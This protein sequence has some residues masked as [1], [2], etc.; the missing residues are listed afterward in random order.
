MWTQQ[1]EQDRSNIK[2]VM[3]HLLNHN[4]KAVKKAGAVGI[5]A[6]ASIEFPL[7]L[8]DNLIPILTDNSN[9]PDL[10]VR[11]SSIMALGFICE[12]VDP[13][14]INPDSMNLILGAVLQNIIPSQLELSQ[15]S[16]KAFQRAAPF[17]QRNF[18]I[19]QQKE[20]IMKALLDAGAS[21]DDE[22]IL[23]A[24]MQSL[25]EIAR[26]NYDYLSDYLNSISSLCTKLINSEHE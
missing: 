24:L 26:Q 1:S 15:I 12:D 17:T 4:D 21:F 14:S 6:I 18:A 8:W 10:N 9:S 2:N 5:S 19:P 20:F 16:M 3:F 23:D 22:D 13:A 11:L 25:V 7:G